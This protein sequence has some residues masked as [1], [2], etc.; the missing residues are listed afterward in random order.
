MT[1]REIRATLRGAT[2]AK[3]IWSWTMVGDDE[4]R[5]FHIVPLAGPLMRKS[6]AEAAEY[7]FMVQELEGIE[8]LYR[9]SEPYIYD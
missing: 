8:P 2:A 9:E 5:E 7:A 4:Y 3:Y 1:N 6:P